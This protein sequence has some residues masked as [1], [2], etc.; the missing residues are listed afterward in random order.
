M[1]KTIGY[2][3]E[4]ITGQI[5]E[6]PHVSQSIEAFSAAN[7]QDYDIS[8]SGSFKVTGS[9]FIEPDT[10]LTQTKTYVL[11]YDTSTGQIF[12][13]LATSAGG[14][15]GVYRTGSNNNNIIPLNFGSNEVSGSFSAIASGNNNFI[16]KNSNCV[17]IGG[18]TNSCISADCTFIGAGQCLVITSSNG[19]S[20][21]AYSNIIGGINNCIINGS[22]SSIIGGATNIIKTVNYNACNNLI[23]TAQSSFISGQYNFIGS[24]ISN[25]ISGSNSAPPLYSSIVN[26]FVNHITASSYTTIVG[27]QNNRINISDKSSIGG[28][29]NNCIENS[30]NSFIGG[31]CLHDIAS[32]NRS[33][34]V[35]G[36]INYISS[37]CSFIGGGA[38]HC[39]Q[40]SGWGVIVGGNSNYISG[41]S[42]TSFIGGGILNI[43]AHTSGRQGSTIGGG[44]CNCTTAN[45]TSILGGCKNLVSGNFSTITGGTCN[46]ASA[47]CSFIGGGSKNIACSVASAI[48]GGTLNT[49]SGTCSFVGGGYNNVI[50]SFNSVIAGGCRNIICSC[51]SLIGG[52]AINCINITGLGGYGVIVGGNLNCIVGT[53][54]NYSIIG[55]GS[56]NYITDACSSVIGSGA[57]N[58][59]IKGSCSA[60]ITGFNNCVELI[61]GAGCSVILAGRDNIVSTGH[62]VIGS[63]CNNIITGS[64]LRYH[65]MGTGCKNVI[66]GS[67]SYSVIVGGTLN[68]S[69][70]ACSFIGGGCL[71]V[72]DSGGS[73]SNIVG[74]QRNF[75][76]GSGTFNTSIVGGLRNTASGA[77]SFIGGGEKNFITSSLGTIV[78]G[79]QNCVYG[80]EG[81]QGC[82]NAILGGSINS[83]I[84]ATGSIR[85]NNTITGGSSNQIFRSVHDSSIVG[86]IGNKILGCGVESVNGN[87]KATRHSFI[88]GGHTNLITDFNGNSNQNVILG[89][90]LNRITQCNTATGAYCVG[91]RNTILNGCANCIIGDKCSFSNV[92]TGGS[93]NKI[94]KFSNAFIAG[95]LSNT[96]SGSAVGNGQES[97]AIIGGCGQRIL[98]S[99]RHSFIGGGFGNLIS[100]SGARNTIMGGYSNRIS[101]T[102]KDSQ[103]LGGCSNIIC[104][105]SNGTIIGGDLNRVD[106]SNSAIIAASNKTT[107]A[108]N[109]L[110]VCNICVFGNQSVG[111]TKSFRIEH[112]DPTKSLTHE[113]VHNSVES[114][115]AGDTMYRFSITTEDNEAEIILPEYY[116]YLNENTQLWVSADGHFGKAFGIVNLS[117]TKIKIT[118]NQDGKYNVMV[119]GTRK[120]KKAVASWKGAEILKNNL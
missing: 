106:H 80:Y 75:I 26:G 88:G 66:S 54:G 79:F 30:C 7:Q 113:L 109:T 58:Q 20:D 107:L 43:I 83:V 115:T 117:A 46:T 68:T 101:V 95:G 49:A 67:N 33:S 31:G 71:N 77:C 28:G 84:A 16:Q 94:C 90:C 62:S 64:G 61:A 15:G 38:S 36:S 1:A 114:P 27:G 111:G 85:A 11:S 42:C 21:S 63:G 102:S 55:N 29:G 104:D 52:G 69:S 103:I 51:N 81:I 41:N 108:S 50:Q 91:K 44:S 18:G 47:S 65:F 60:I 110:Y 12:K 78:G 56:G 116:R 53:G 93:Y 96:I 72:I 19:C 86:G 118:S 10:L 40:G 23:G 120:D 89:G 6:A 73:L 25:Q 22:K 99:T 98:G 8:I 5:V 76:S 14:S 74:G 57:N 24:G 119:V 97:A 35:G 87:G 100:G 105:V 34:I 48:V 3:S 45:H 39:I 32:A 9:Q 82:G 92:V 112:P 4:V 37:P 59:I 70:G 17:F 13:M 2:S